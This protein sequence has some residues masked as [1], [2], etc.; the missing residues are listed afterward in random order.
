MRKWK[1]FHTRVK[2]KCLLYVPAHAHSL[3]L[4]GILSIIQP[5]MAISAHVHGSLARAEPIPKR[6]QQRFLVLGG[7][8]QKGVILLKQRPSRSETLSVDVRVFDKLAPF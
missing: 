1:K 5:L 3:T 8:S 7:F 6:P 4:R 2:V